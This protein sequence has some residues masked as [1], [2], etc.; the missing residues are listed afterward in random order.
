MI[1]KNNEELKQIAL[2]IHS[3]KIFTDRHIKNSVD[4]PRVFMILSLLNRKQ[5]NELK[6]SNPGLIYEYI[7]KAGSIAVNG[8]PSF[9]SYKTLSQKEFK[10]VMSYH[11][12]IEEAIKAVV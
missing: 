1:M 11:K 3:G 5:I 4:V 10:K 8:Y 2:D 9:L 12:K 7:E 6:N